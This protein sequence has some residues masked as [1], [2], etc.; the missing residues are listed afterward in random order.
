M[1]AY[2]PK[3]E[4]PLFLE[5]PERLAPHPQEQILTGIGVDPLR[6][7]SRAGWCVWG[8]GARR[9]PVNLL[10]DQ[11][12]ASWL[13]SMDEI[14][15]RALEEPCKTRTS[16]GGASHKPGLSNLRAFW[17][18]CSKTRHFS[19]WARKVGLSGRAL[20]QAVEEMVRGLIN[21]GLGRLH[22]QE[23]D[24][25]RWPRQAW[26]SANTHRDEQGRPVVFRLWL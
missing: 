7:P 8:G 21:A 24:R 19:R 5:V 10:R 13:I 12:L 22:Y 15:V 4:P 9:A 23:A 1:W 3:E 25:A 26:R 6:V 11:L 18:G 2:R 14:P 20:C 16:R 17:T